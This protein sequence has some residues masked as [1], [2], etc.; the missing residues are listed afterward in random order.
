MIFESLDFPSH[1]LTNISVTQS[2]LTTIIM[3]ETKASA[4]SSESGTPGKVPTPHEA[5]FFFAIVKHTKNKADID[6]EGV[7]QEQGFKSAEVAK[8][9]LLRFLSP[10]LRL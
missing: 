4:N 8:V 5:M 1:R 7:A 10:K 2:I 3:A 6:W 9:R